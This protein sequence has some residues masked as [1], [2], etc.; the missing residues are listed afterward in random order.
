MCPPEIAIKSEEVDDG[1][2]DLTCCHHQGAK[3][4]NAAPEPLTPSKTLDQVRPKPKVEDDSDDVL[5]SLCG[6]FD[7]MWPGNA[8]DDNSDTES[9]CS[10][11]RSKGSYDLNFPTINYFS[12]GNRVYSFDEYHNVFSQDEY[13]NPITIHTGQPFSLDALEVEFIEGLPCYFGLD[14]NLWYADQTTTSPIP[15]WTNHMLDQALSPAPANVLE[16]DFD[17]LSGGFGLQEHSIPVSNGAYCNTKS[18]TKSETSMFSPNPLHGSL[19]GQ[20]N[21]P[22][23]PGSS[24]MSPII[25]S[26]S[27]ASSEGLEPLITQDTLGWLGSVWKQETESIQ[28]ARAPVDKMQRRRCPNCQKVFRRP[29]SLDDHL[30]VHTGNK[31][32]V[33]PYERCNTGFATKSNMKRHFA[34]HR[35]GALEEYSRS[36]KSMKAKS[37]TATYNSKAFH[38]QRFRLTAS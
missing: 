7:G 6:L 10:S 23:S 3:A 20:A 32:H 17:F 15:T 11:P 38:T 4:K 1:F 21:L 22:W 36:S 13:G 8:D 18:E 26:G 25:A 9:D 37:R 16:P 30:N 33:C 14:G 29:S 27:R 34:T 2:P 12:I 19:Q 5:A 31:P 35:V 28:Q 24:A